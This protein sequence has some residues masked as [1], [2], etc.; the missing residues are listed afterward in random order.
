LR[1][2]AW[3]VRINAAEFA[4]LFDD[5]ESKAAVVAGLK[6]RHSAV[7]GAAELALRR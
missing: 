6:D 4:G 3:Q 5:R 7:R 1:D 2:E